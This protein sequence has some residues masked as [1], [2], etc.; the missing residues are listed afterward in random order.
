MNGTFKDIFSASETETVPSNS[1]HVVPI[2]DVE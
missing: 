2:T 1:E